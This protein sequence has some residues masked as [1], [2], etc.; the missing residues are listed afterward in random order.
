MEIEGR[1]EDSLV[2][3]KMAYIA[4]LILIFV[5][6]LA[7]ISIYIGYMYPYF[8]NAEITGLII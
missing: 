1:T 5:L 4:I 3:R 2:I 8:Y 7:L 6:L